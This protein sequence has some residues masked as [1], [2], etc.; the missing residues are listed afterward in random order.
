MVTLE[1]I[2]VL[3]A[4]SLELQIV[5]VAALRDNMAQP[6]IKTNHCATWTPVPI[7]HNSGNAR[8]NDGGLG[9]AGC[10]ARACSGN[11]GGIA[12]VTARKP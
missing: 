7:S 8:K 10:G 4:S 11:N 3:I 2:A 6:L 9:N 5:H 12:S 1:S